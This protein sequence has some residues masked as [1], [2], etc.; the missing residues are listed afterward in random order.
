MKNG[1]FYEGYWLNNMRSG[2]GRNITI[3]GDVYTG[4]WLSDM[5]NGF[6]E[7]KD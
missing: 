5:P 2:K 6:G 4:D 7:E 1:D 3:N